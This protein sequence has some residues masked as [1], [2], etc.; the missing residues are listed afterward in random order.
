MIYTCKPTKVGLVLLLRRLLS[1]EDK[2]GERL[3][4]RSFNL[5]LRRERVQIIWTF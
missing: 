1:N 4:W 5:N 2:T 3:N